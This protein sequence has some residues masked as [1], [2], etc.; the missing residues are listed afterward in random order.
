M[1]FLTSIL[2]AFGDLTAGTDWVSVLQTMLIAA[3]VIFGIGA[4]FR[5]IFGKG[6]SL[7]RAVSATLSILMVYL[8]AILI[9]VFVPALRSDVNQLPF[10]SVT[11]E[12]LFLW[13]ISSLPSDLLYA[14]L[15]KMAILALLVNILETFLPQGKKFFTWYL[16]RSFTALSALTLYVVICHLIQTFVPAVFGEWAGYVLIGAWAVILATGILKILLSVVL[17]IVNP[18]IGALYTFFFSNAIGKQFSKSILTTVLMTLLVIGLNNSGLTQF[19]FSQF[20]ATS[21]GPAC[22]IVVIMLYLFGKFL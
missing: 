1:E 12:K 19:A 18:I 22:V 8:A 17:T 21:Y 15:V 4:I 14:S 10:L 13:D 11:Q 20:S 5:S 16:W 9:F 3:V 7:T 2:P 6:S